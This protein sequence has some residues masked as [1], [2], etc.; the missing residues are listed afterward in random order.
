M[1]SINSDVEP[2]DETQ[3]QEIIKETFG[4][5]N[6][7]GFVFASASPAAK[8][9]TKKISAKHN[10]PLGARPVWRRNH[11]LLSPRRVPLAPRVSR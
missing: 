6:E 10:L 5:A 9:K 7:D 2:D 11:F 8:N 1:A 4:V 3:S